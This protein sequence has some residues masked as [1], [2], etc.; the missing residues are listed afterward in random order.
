M[1]GN[2]KNLGE[3][4]WSYIVESIS[5]SI[6]SILSSPLILWLR[7]IRVALSS[8][9]NGVLPE[10]RLSTFQASIRWAKVLYCT[11]TLDL[12]VP[13]LTRQ[14]LSTLERVFIFFHDAIPSSFHNHQQSSHHPI[15]TITFN[16]I[17]S[18]YDCL[19][20]WINRWVRTFPHS[21]SWNIMFQPCSCSASS[22]LKVPWQPQMQLQPMSMSRLMSPLRLEVQANVKHNSIVHNFSPITTPSKR[23]QK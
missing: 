4:P 13:S 15:H 9:L 3:W 10:F 12:N 16:Q 6:S 22:Q 18:P 11:C 17:I 8:V 1:Y 20:P 2:S 21:Q 19:Y 14:R 5:L 23:D 7:C